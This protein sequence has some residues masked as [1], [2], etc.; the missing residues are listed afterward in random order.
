MITH[1]INTHQAEFWILVGFLLLAIEVLIMG[2]TSGVLLFAGL[3]GLATGLL[4]L[5]GV[6]PETWI[7]GFAGF[8]ISSGVIAAVLWKPLS[9]IQADRV[10]VRNTSTDLIGLELR[11]E[12]DV[13]AS[14]PGTQRYSGITWK[15]EIDPDAGIDSLASGHK[16]VVTAADVGRLWVRPM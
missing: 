5:A 12:N 10:P 8:G 6:L 14:L 2:F 16:V 3:G 11:L 9:R 15:I 7:A 4:M 1:Y 13:T